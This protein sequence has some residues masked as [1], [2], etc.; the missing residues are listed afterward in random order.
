MPAIQAIT[1][2][3]ETIGDSALD[4]LSKEQ[5]AET[6]EMVEKGLAGLNTL[7]DRLR[8]KT[9]ARTHKLTAKC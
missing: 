2:T 3:T 1:M 5:R 4:G 9:R 6:I 7:L 8:P